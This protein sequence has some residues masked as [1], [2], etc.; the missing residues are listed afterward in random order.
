MKRLF[1][2][3]LGIVATAGVLYWRAN[4]AEYEQAYAPTEPGTIEIKTLPAATIIRATTGKPYFEKDNEL[5]MPLFRYIE[6]REIAMTTPVE[7]DIEPGA[8]AFFIGKDVPS[9]ALTES[10]GIEIQ[11]VPQRQVL[12]VGIRGSYSEENYRQALEKARAWLDQHPQWR[13]DGPSRMVYW[14][15]PFKLPWQ[16]A[17][18]LHL[19]V[20]TGASS[21]AE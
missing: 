21:S 20:K 6:K 14:D 1:L 11:K 13:E 8:M 4:A 16:K 2:I 12:S 3:G 9:A 18:E 7:A 5:F 10:E 17:S 15:A 19:P